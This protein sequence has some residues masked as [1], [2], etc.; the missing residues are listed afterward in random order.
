MSS[1][2]LMLRQENQLIVNIYIICALYKNIGQVPTLIT[3]QQQR[4]KASKSKWGEYALKSDPYCGS[5]SV[6][7][8][9]QRHL[10][11]HVLKLDLKGGKG[12]CIVYMKGDAVPSISGYL[13]RKG[14]VSKVSRRFLDR[15]GWWWKTGSHMQGCGGKWETSNKEEQACGGQKRKFMLLARTQW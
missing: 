4:W 9:C 13:M 5:D 3:I 6:D 2:H 10:R 11:K 12:G 14:L 8:N 7:S 1:K 15:R